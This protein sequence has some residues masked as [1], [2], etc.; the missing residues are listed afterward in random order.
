M[1]IDMV[2]N[3]FR[4][5]NTNDKDHLISE[6]RRLSNLDVSNEICS[7]YLEMAEW[8]LNTAL[9]AFYEYEGSQNPALI[10]NMF[11]ELPEMQYLSD[12]TNGEGE[13]IQPN[14]KFIKSW[15]IINSGVY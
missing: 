15:R 2:L 10:R 8:N 13:S 3:Q 4:T 6:F 1:D 5:M 9:W 7:F 12:I 11:F 14:T